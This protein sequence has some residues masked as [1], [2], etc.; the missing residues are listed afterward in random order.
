M[1]ELHGE[2]LRESFRKAKTVNRHDDGLIEHALLYGYQIFS[3]AS[4]LGITP[5][6]VQGVR[7]EMP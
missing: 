6:Y 5:E 7:R 3:I 4:R 1:D 2:A